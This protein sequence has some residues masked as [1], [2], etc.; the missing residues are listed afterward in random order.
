MQKAYKIWVLLLL[1][2]LGAGTALAAN[3]P[4]PMEYY[5]IGPSDVIELIV[6][7]EQPLSRSEILV[8][9]D[10]RISLPLADDIRAA[11]LTPMELK[12]EVTRSLKRFIEEPKVYV[13]IREPRSYYYSI[14]GNVN[15]PGRFNLLAPT[16][17]LQA[18]AASEGFNEWASKNDVVILRGQGSQQKRFRFKY[19]EVISGDEEKMKQ[20][21]PL[22]P[23][24]VIVVP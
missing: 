12:E 19:S 15:K 4:D 23:G 3:P 16:T 5:I 24:D 11:G 1:L 7:R 17:V 22:K 20:N 8:R 10:G 6:W 2:S 13:I 9:P 21:I 18:L 14:L